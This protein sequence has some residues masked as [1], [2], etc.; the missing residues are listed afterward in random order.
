MGA[1]VPAQE[2]TVKLDSVPAGYTV[3]ADRGGALGTVERTPQGGIKVPAQL[4]TSGVFEYVL[5]DGRVQ[6]EYRP[7]EEVANPAFLASLEAAPVLDNHP[8]GEP[9]GLVSPANFSRLSKGHNSGPKMDEQGFA[10]G[11]LYVQDAT[12]IGKIDRG[13]AREISLGILSKDI[14]IAGTTPDGKPY[15]V[16]QTELRANHVA[17]VPK[18]RVAGSRIKLDS[19]GLPALEA[20]EEKVKPMRK[21]KIDG[22]EFP[23][24]TEAEQLAA[25]QAMDRL[26]AKLDSAAS[27]AKA[28]L[29]TLKGKLDAATSEVAGLKTKLDAATDPKALEALVAAK[30]ALRETASLILGKEEVAKL[31][32]DLAI[33]LA[34]VAKAYPEVKLDAKT[35]ETRPDY[36]AG[37][38]DSAAVKAKADS[39][40][41][42]Q[43]QEVLKTLAGG[44]T[45]PAPKLDAKGTESPEQTWQ[46]EARSMAS[47]PLAFSKK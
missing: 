45:G 34:V 47:Q 44:N 6:R 24:G 18:G 13:E 23:L 39:S 12:L 33:K 3:K 17:V 15:D 4:T 42:G 28:E 10:A 36:L 26:Q 9:Q 32:S 16:R 19:D 30:A 2:R 43:T 20:L 1:L 8:Y 22:V 5:P 31:D 37:L 27:A 29:E 14:H 21:I 7:P 35:A 38:F 41:S 25:V 46:K 11:T 40:E